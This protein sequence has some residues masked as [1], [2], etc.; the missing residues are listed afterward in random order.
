ML[1]D[2]EPEDDERAGMRSGR[3]ITLLD[4][5][6]LGMVG[7]TLLVIGWVLI[8]MRDPYGPFNPFPPPPPPT[9]VTIVPYEPPAGAEVA[10]VW[11]AAPTKTVAPT[12]T[13]FEPTPAASTTPAATATPAVLPT[14]SHTPAAFFFTLEGEAV[15]YGPNAN[16]NECAWQSIAGQVIGVEGEPVI[17]LYVHISGE[18]VDELVLTGSQPAFGSS[19]YEL[20]LGSAPQQGRYVVQLIGQN[21]EA[22]SDRVIVE[23]IDR[24]EQ[25]VAL[26]NFVQNR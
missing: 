16:E 4:L 6:S 12:A 23:T 17:G 21:G 9:Q 18:G 3:R 11:V 20:M 1:E 22:L 19:G 13:P 2:R 10:P 8:V 5:A 7:L 14:P 25:N 26:V 15:G 24:C